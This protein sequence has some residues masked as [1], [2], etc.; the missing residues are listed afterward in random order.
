MR[1][2]ELRL[3]LI[4]G[5]LLPIM[6]SVVSGRHRSSQENA[7]AATSDLHPAL[8]VINPLTRGKS[9][10]AVLIVNHYTRPGLGAWWMAFA[11]AATFPS[12]IHWIMTSAWVHPDRLRSL[13]MTTISRWVLRRLAQMYGFTS[14]PPTP[15][16]TYEV[17]ARAAAIR[18]LLRDIDQ[19]PG[20]NIGLTLKGA[21]SGDGKL[22][23]PPAGVGRF[24]QLLMDRG[25]QVI[26][27]GIYEQDSHTMTFSWELRSSH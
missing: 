19:A 6:G 12:E 14:M 3:L 22:A 7:L 21:D 4:P 11:L 26:P 23:R 20:I 17:A 8:R 15:P 2:A 5:W 25:L 27:V 13:I 1:S 9:R 16:Q 18:S 24:L 10:A